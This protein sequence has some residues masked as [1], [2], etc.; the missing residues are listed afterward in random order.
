MKIKKQRWNELNDLLRTI[1]EWNNQKEIGTTKQVMISR[2][3]KN[4]DY[5][6]YTENMKNIVVKMPVGTHSNISEEIIW[7]FVQVRISWAE[8]FKLFGEIV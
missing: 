8:A 6:G 1:S 5:F 7:S 3:L 4:G 2:K